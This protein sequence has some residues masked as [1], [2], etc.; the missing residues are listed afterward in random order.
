MKKTNQQSLVLFDFDGTLSAGDANIG[1][2]KYCFAHSMRPWLFSPIVA[3][4]FVL[5]FFTFIAKKIFCIK[6]LTKFDLIWRQMLR[7]YL[8]HDMVKKFA[9]RFIAEYKQSRFGW[10]AERVA[11]ESAAGNTVIM[12][13]ASPAY[14]LLP[15]VE[16]MGF[17]YII[18]SDVELTRP[19]K[20]KFFAYGE[21]KVKILRAIFGKNKYVVVRAYSDSKSDLPMMNLAAEQVW[22]D[23]KTGL[24]KC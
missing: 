5:Q 11:A 6:C 24:R 10:A 4:A 16:D 7:M 8:T 22:I 13:S 15:L 2:F 3:S 19:W 9:P 20:F 23:P 14:L 12:I 17:D 1:F 18:C 21:N